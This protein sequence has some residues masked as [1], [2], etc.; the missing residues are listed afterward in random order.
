MWKMRNLTFYGKIVV[1]KS[2]VI[3][4]IVYVASVLCVPKSFVCKLEKIIYTFLWGSKREKVKRT[5]CI[6]SIEKGGIGNDRFMFKVTLIKT[7][8]D[9]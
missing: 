7:F 9:H 8:V 3:S 6:N 2:L 1:L 4:Q 5:V